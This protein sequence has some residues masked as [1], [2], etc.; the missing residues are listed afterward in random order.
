M[1]KELLQSAT[2]EQ[3]HLFAN[4]LFE[5]LRPLPDMLDETESIL[6]ESVCGPH[7]NEH[8]LSKALSN[9]A[10]D[11]G[12]KGGHWSVQDT[13]N[14]AAQTGIQLNKYN[15]YDWNYVMNMLYSDYYTIG[16][17]DPQFYARMAFRFLADTDAPDGKA[18]KYYKAMH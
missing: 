11:D 5:R 13:N 14:V 16:G 7:F 6:Y 17:D 18:Y 3:L 12:T 2:N 8:T 15:E 1:Y 9:M 10:N 4:T